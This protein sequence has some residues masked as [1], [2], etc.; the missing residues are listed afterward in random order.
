MWRGRFRLAFATVRWGEAGIQK[1]FA[2]EETRRPHFQTRVS[3]NTDMI[4]A[5]ETAE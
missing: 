4:L 1:P 2:Y 3:A 5:H